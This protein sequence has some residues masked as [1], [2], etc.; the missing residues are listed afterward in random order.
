M[1]LLGVTLLSRSLRAPMV[2]AM[3]YKRKIQKN[4]GNHGTLKVLDGIC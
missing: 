4:H 1:Q 3:Q 2:V